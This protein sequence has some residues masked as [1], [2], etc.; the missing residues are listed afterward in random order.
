[1]RGPMWPLSSCG[2]PKKNTSKIRATGRT[3]YVVHIKKNIVLDPPKRACAFGERAG[4]WGRGGTYN[5]DSRSFEKSSFCSAD[6]FSGTETTT[7]TNRSP[8]TDGLS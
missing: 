1:M 3:P 4:G 6:S 8:R 5:P 7:V 2:H